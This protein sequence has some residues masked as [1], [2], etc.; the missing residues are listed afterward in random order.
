LRFLPNAEEKLSEPRGSYG[1]E[2]IEQCHLETDFLS[3]LLDPPVV[4]RDSF[5]QRFDLSE[6]RIQD[7]P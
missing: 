3:D 6:K 5:V 2:G 4:F 1:V 7:I